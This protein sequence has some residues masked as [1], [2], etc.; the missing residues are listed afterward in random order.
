M[1]DDMNSN[2]MI[3]FEI[4]YLVNLLRI[5]KA[6]QGTNDELEYQIKVQKNKLAAL[7][8][9]TASYEFD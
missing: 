4:N 3:N 8:V 5:K 7:G 9:N 6:E 1:N 2:E